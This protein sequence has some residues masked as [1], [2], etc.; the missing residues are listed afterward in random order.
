MSTREI[1]VRIYI[2]LTT[3]SKPNP[4]QN[5][6]LDMQTSSILAV[7]NISIVM[8]NMLEQNLT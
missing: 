7:T 8:K 2:K 6:F 3:I 5:N 1:N 4:T